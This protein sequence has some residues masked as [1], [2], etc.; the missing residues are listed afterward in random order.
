MIGGLA[1]FYLITAV[2]IPHFSTQGFQYWNYPDLGDG[3]E[4]ALIGAVTHP[5]KVIVLL[6]YPWTKT[7]TWACLLVPL[8]FLPLR[9]PYALIVAPIMASRMLAGRWP[10]WT[11]HFH[12]NAVVWIV[13]AMASVDAVERLKA[14][15]AEWFGAKLGGVFRWVGT[16]AG[17]VFRRRRSRGGAPVSATVP[18]RATNAA[19]APASHPTDEVFPAP[20]AARPPASPSPPA[21]TT[22]VSPPTDV[23]ESARQALAKLL[24]TFLVL[25]MALSF[26]RF[27]P[28]GTMFALHRLFTDE[29]W[30]MTPIQQD[31]AAAAAWLPHNTCV[32]A[33]DYV[34]GQLTSTNR[35]TLPGISDHRQDFYVLDMSAK[36]PGTTPV[37]WTTK[38]SYDHAID[39]GFHEVYRADVIVILQS[40]D[41][42]G[43]NPSACG[44]DAP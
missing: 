28:M 19:S 24:V 25:G 13:I 18:D 14:S 34:A 40:A 10:L 36:V 41:Y 2:I 27:Q 42:T 26:T 37:E 6:F 20:T 35:V 32:A 5:W 7:L 30:R 16:T 44:P 43:P 15:H 12:Y 8:A 17:R 22:P 31:R 1:A 33:D 38:Q 11:V 3:P 9:S 23:R 29:A 4:G 39:L 21:P